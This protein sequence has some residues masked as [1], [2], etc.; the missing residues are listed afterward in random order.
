MNEQFNELIAYI[1]Q[2]LNH[3]IPEENI[4]YAL[5]QH[6]W[7]TDL[8]NH[9]FE[10]VKSR[11]P[12][13]VAQQPPSTQPYNQHSQGRSQENTHM[14]PASDSEPDH[15]SPNTSAP[16]KYR[17]FKAIADAFSAIKNNAGVFVATVIISYVVATGTL[18]IVSFAIDKLLYGDF[19]LLFA[20]TSKLL[21]VLFGSLILY[22]IWYAFAGAFIF[23]TTSIAIYDGGKKT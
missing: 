6:S 22:S 8:I 17:V 19:G 20:S 12:A 1:R 4:R 7:N 21:T 3:G 13:S 2:C 23:A 10:V 11:N 15:I 5:L 9:A 14:Q 18:F 16:Q